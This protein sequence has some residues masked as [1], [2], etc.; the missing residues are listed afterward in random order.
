MFRKIFLET[1][2]QKCNFIQK[3]LFSKWRLYGTRA[4]K[5][6][7]VPNDMRKSYDA[8]NITKCFL[9]ILIFCP[10]FSQNS[11]FRSL[12]LVLTSCSSLVEKTIID[13]QKRIFTP[14]RERMELVLVW[15]R[16]FISATWWRYF[17]GE[18]L[19]YD[20]LENY[21]YKKF[22]M[23]SLCEKLFARRLPIWKI[24]FFF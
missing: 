20:F 1:F 5:V 23:P 17:S 18:V 2:V 14:W 19:K 11:I 22:H 4:C 16:Y 21:T 10:N 12:L 3:I 15:D 6:L 9:E 24:Q 8:D 13:T 7:H